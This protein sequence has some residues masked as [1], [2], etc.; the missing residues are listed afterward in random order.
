MIVWL[1][2]TTGSGK[3]SLGE[4][5]AAENFEMVREIIPN[6]LFEQF[7]SEPARHC[8]QLQEEIMLARRSQ[9]IALTKST[10]V[11]FDRSVEEDIEVFCRL[12]YENKLLTESELESLRSLAK[13]ISS[14]MPSPDIILFMSPPAET[15]QDRLKRNGHPVAIL[16]SLQQQIEFYEEWISTRSDDVLKID[17]SRCS[18]EA[19]SRL[20]GQRT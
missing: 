4:L 6:F 11:V 7:R 18:F 9:W 14:T 20:L 10:N 1:S 8:A 3:S 16:D 17:N 2:G 19:I 13:E 15:L 12:H 5:F